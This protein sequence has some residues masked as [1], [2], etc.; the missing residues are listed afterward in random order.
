MYVHTKGFFLSTNE[1]F[2]FSK[3]LKFSVH[4]Y[5]LS[6]MSFL[7]IEIVKNFETLPQFI[8]GSFFHDTNDK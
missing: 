7:H 4:T 6:F 5:D 1:T 8:Y 3:S 2:G